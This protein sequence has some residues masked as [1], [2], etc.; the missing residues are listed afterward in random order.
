MKALPSWCRVALPILLSQILLLGAFPAS[1]QSPVKLTLSHNAAANTPRADAALKF[2]ELVKAKSNGRIVVD[3]NPGGKLG[4]NLEML[5]DLR[6]GSLDMSINTHGTLATVVPEVGAFGLPYAFSSPAKVWE[7]LD[8]SIGQELAKKIEAQGMMTLGWMDNGARHISNNKRPILKPDDMA[9]MKIRTTSDK[10]MM[11]SMKA[12]GANP[13]PIGFGDLYDA[14][15]IGYVDGQE[16]PLT[17]FKQKKMHEV[18]KHLAITYH[19]YGLA[20]FLMSNQSWSKLSSDDRKTI[21]AAAQEAVVLQRKM[22]DEVDDKIL[23]EYKKMPSVAITTPD[24]A[25]FKAATQKVWDSWELKPFGA[26]VK[27]L[28]AASN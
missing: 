25:P 22:S 3:I 5:T 2:A 17:N 8:G 1:A 15:K 13:V 20:P 14:M 11:D 12:L 9:G 19:S 10:V 21:Q 23:E 27:K 16:N 4:E 26:F 28:R 24:P 18:Q 7:I 6:T